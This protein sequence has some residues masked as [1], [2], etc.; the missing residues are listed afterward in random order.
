MNT[1]QSPLNAVE[2]GL[3]QSHSAC[4]F[5]LVLGQDT[6]YF[7]LLGGQKFVINMEFRS[8]AAGQDSRNSQS[9]LGAGGDLT[10]GGPSTV[11]NAMGQGQVALLI[12]AIQ[13]QREYSERDPVEGFVVH[14]V[15]S[16]LMGVGRMGLKKVNKDSR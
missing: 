14:D 9:L 11:R 12:F 4:H 3:A 8:R 5:S 15:L 6:V 16:D 10:E 2:I 1:V 7:R 13:S